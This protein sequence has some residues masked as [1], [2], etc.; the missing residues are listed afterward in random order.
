MAHP[1]CTWC[2]RV[3]S[4]HL[5]SSQDELGPWATL[6]IML[7]PSHFGQY[8][9]D[10]FL[11]FFQDAE[12]TWTPV[13][14]LLSLF[15]SLSGAGAGAGTRTRTT[16][17]QSQP[18]RRL[19]CAGHISGRH[20]LVGE[21]LCPLCRGQCWTQHLQAWRPRSRAQQRLD[22]PGLLEAASSCPCC[23]LEA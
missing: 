9:D 22:A 19:A 17:G 4:Q 8:L 16:R 13:S 6:V 11:V 12:L 23:A 1:S 3:P 5:L 18:Q 20:H 14:Q 2:P 15:C 10:L 7:L 21:A